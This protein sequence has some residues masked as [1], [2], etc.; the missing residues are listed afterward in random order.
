MN[1]PEASRFP[2]IEHMTRPSAEESGDLIIT[3]GQG[4]GG[5]CEDLDGDANRILEYSATGEPLAVEIGFIGEG[6]DLTGLPS[7]EALRQL[8]EAEGIRV[9]GKG[10]HHW[11]RVCRLWQTSAGYWFWSAVHI[12]RRWVGL[13]STRN[14]RVEHVVLPSDGLGWVIELYQDRRRRWYWGVALGGRGA[15]RCWPV[16][17]RGELHVVRQRVGGRTYDPG[18]SGQ[19]VRLPTARSRGGTRAGPWWLLPDHHV[20]R[21]HKQVVLE[22]VGSCRECRKPRAGSLPGS[23]FGNG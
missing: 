6:V 3:L 22:P 17:L 18:G 13:T 8:L 5:G 23:R 4:E 9:I 11:R 2:F 14:R 12:L 19:T 20:S 16:H 10:E 21:R 1:D 7:Q 15:T